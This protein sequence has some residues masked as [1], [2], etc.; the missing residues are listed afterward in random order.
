MGWGHDGSQ[1]V[2][3]HCA[4]TLTRRKLKLGDFNI[5]VCNIQKVSFGSL[6]YPALSL[7]RVCQGVL[8]IF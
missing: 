5:D 1:N 4:Q 8:E 6:G 7:Q 2:F 3:A